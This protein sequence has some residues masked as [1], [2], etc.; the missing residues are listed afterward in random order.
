MSSSA[1]NFRRL[2][3]S[4][5]QVISGAVLLLSLIGVA[6]N[7]SKVDNEVIVPPGE[8]FRLAAGGTLLVLMTYCFLNTRDGQ[9]KNP[10]PGM[11]RMLHGST[12]WCA[13]LYI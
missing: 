1:N 4:P 12:L 2:D 5:R 3:E 11:W 10:H 9:L 7:Q 13:L 8:S 6:Y